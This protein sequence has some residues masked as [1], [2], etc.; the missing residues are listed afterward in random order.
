M[1]W[2][3]M[4]YA[5]FAEGSAALNRLKNTD[6]RF[7]A[8]PPTGNPPKSNVSMI[9]MGVARQHWNKGCHRLSQ[10]WTE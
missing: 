5:T 1:P 9:V 3:F 2:G 6:L 7:Q 10:L 4:S 8:K